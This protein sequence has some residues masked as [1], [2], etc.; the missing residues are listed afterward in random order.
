MEGAQRHC[1]GALTH[2]LAKPLTQLTV[3]GSPRLLSAVSAL[4]AKLGKA[5]MPDRQGSDA[6]RPADTLA[7][8]SG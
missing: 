3:H 4:L 8:P 1:H 7:L 6:R 5:M 2:Q